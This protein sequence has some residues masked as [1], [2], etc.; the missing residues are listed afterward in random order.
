MRIPC[1]G[2]KGHQFLSV[3]NSTAITGMPRVAPIVSP[4]KDLQ[5][6]YSA[7]AYSNAQMI[8]RNDAA[9]GL[10][11]LSS[12]DRPFRPF[13]LWQDTFCWKQAA[14]LPPPARQSLSCVREIIG[15]GFHGKGRNGSR[16]THVQGASDLESDTLSRETDVV[17]HE[18]AVGF[19]ND[20]TI[21]P[22]VE[23]QGL[24]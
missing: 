8:S 15:L 16:R 13:P 4:E 22:L 20:E 19:L 11:K 14:L 3:G 18:V 2:N 21:A 17:D 10:S 12:S 7:I 6:M 9:Q 24:L 23:V 1:R 5:A